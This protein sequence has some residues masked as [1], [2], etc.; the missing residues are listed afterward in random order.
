MDRGSCDF[1]AELA[2]LFPSSVFLG[3]MGL[4]WEELGTL[5]SMRDG[6][7]S[8]SPTNTAALRGS[9]RLHHND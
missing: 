3:M 5:V 6:L 9:R 2:E 8:T 4:P 1:T 7:G